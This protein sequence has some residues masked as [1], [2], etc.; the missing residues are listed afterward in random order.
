MIEILVPQGLQ[1]LLAYLDSQPTCLHIHPMEYRI[2]RRL[3]EE[4]LLG[5]HIT[6]REEMEEGVSLDLEV[7]LVL[8]DPRDHRV[9]RDLEA[10]PESQAKRALL[11]PED[12]PVHQEF[13]EKM[14]SKARTVIREL[15]G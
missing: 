14:E 6:F 5:D 10:S 15:L 8:Q 7:H 9:F 3:V 13:Q 1:V 4:H 2:R 11:E 12:H